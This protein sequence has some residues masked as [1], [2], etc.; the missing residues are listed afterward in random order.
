LHHRDSV[1]KSAPLAANNS[2]NED[3]FYVIRVVSDHHLGSPRT[4]KAETLRAIQKFFE[5]HKDPQY[6]ED[7]KIKHIV[8]LGDVFEAWLTPLHEK[9]PTIK[10]LL[11]SGS[12]RFRISFPDIIDSIKAIADECGATVWIMRGNHDDRLSR[13]LVAELFGDSVNYAE[14]VLVFPSPDKPLVK[15]QHG[16][17]NDLFNRP[18][19]YGRPSTCRAA[20]PT[21]ITGR[22]PSTKM[23]HRPR[24]RAFT[25]GSVSSLSR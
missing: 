25:G 6:I 12:E 7:E 10:G 17:L 23:L 19:P 3:G 4:M 24:K 15:M 5:F 14:D 1:H 20:R 21:H 11:T 22:C 8:F 16:H 18:D 9:C 2:S 13:E